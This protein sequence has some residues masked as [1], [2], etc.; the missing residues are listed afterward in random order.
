[1]RQND[2]SNVQQ[3]QALVSPWGGKHPSC[4]STLQFTPSTSTAFFTSEQQAFF[5]ISQQHDSPPSRL[6]VSFFF[7]RAYA[8]VVLALLNTEAEN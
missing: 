5:T 3:H 1:M 2:G 7:T 6:V 4:Y 8:S